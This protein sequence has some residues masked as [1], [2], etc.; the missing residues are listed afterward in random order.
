MMT[1]CHNV[2]GT[3][4]SSTLSLL[5]CIL[6]WNLVSHVFVSTGI[7]Y[8]MSCFVVVAKGDVNI[9]NITHHCGYSDDGEYV[10]MVTVEQVAMTTRMAFVVASL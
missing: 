4:F 7:F 8:N 10:A 3:G 2:T 1:S 6:S 5:Q 9:D